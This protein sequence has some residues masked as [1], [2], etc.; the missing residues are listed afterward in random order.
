MGAEMFIPLRKMSFFI[1]LYR[2]L[3]H[4]DKGP[5]NY[6]TLNTVKIVRRFSS[7]YMRANKNV[8]IRPTFIP[9]HCKSHYL[10][11]FDPTRSAHLNVVC[12]SCRCYWKH[13]CGFNLHSNSRVYKS[14]HM[15]FLSCVKVPTR[16]VRPHDCF[17]PH[18]F[19]LTVLHTLSLD[20]TWSEQLTAS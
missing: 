11:H 15:M 13:I 2:K 19:Q 17:L 4:A 10:V 18:P 6:A 14:Y 3:K 9:F 12:N 7:N 16:K 5:V 1:L 20:G 8:C